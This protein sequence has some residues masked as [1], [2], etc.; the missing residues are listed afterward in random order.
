[1]GKWLKGLLISAAFL[2]FSC[3]DGE[4]SVKAGVEQPKKAA[5]ESRRDA[6]NGEQEAEAAKDTADQGGYD[7]AAAGD[8]HSRLW[9][10]TIKTNALVYLRRHKHIYKKT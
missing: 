7:S 3:N 9:E 8:D 6:E 2:F 4:T 10:T 5:A 1:M